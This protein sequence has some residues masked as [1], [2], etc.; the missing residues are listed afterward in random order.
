[1]SLNTTETAT[2]RPRK[3]R[4]PKRPIKL[5]PPPDGFQALL[6]GFALEVV[7]QRPADIYKF[8]A[9]HF[10]DLLRRRQS[11][12]GPTVNDEARAAAAADEDSAAS[13]EAANK[14][15]S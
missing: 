9:T 1:S 8:G 4:H 7:R 11:G 3:R 15:V 13:P 6:E 10:E 5:P 2:E 12:N 14:R